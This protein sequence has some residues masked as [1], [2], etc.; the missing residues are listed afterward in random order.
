[1]M[2]LRTYLCACTSLS[3]FIPDPL[4]KNITNLI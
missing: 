1:M 3:S 2:P 4:K